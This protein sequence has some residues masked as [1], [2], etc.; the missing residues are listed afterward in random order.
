MLETE[1]VL[2]NSEQAYN[3]AAKDYG[4]D[5]PCFIFMAQRSSNKKQ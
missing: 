3:E 2:I 5:N 1:E 4:A